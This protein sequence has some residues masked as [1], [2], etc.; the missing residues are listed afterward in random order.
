MSVNDDVLSQEIDKRLQELK[1]INEHIVI[2]LR[3][4]QKTQSMYDIQ[5]Y[6]QLCS[7]WEQKYKDL[8]KY[9]EEQSIV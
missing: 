7:L 2:A 9:I 6:E 5:Y 3:Q 4:A 1:K 8:K